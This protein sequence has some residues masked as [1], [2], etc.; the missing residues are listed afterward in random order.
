MVIKS[1][2]VILLFLYGVAVGN[3]H[4]FPYKYL[5]YVKDIIL[6]GEVQKKI[7]QQYRP[8]ITQH[9]IIK[10]KADVVMF[11]DSLTEDGALVGISLSI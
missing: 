11:G 10:G 2:L 9:K 4:I 3:Y 1:S 8:I 7:Y 6:R 5:K